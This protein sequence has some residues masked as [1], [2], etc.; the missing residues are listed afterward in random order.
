MNQL[1]EMVRQEEVKRR[2]FVEG[3]RRYTQRV[4]TANI[5]EIPLQQPI[6]DTII[7][8]PTQKEQEKEIEAKAEFSPEVKMIFKQSDNGSLE[9]KS[10]QQEGDSSAPISRLDFDKLKCKLD[11]ILRINDR[12]EPYAPSASSSDL[13]KVFNSLNDYT[14]QIFNLTQGLTLVNTKINFLKVDLQ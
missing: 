3:A 1:L 5:F 14:T 2:R 11:V 7:S 6:N 4:E 12:H 8:S 13:K 10:L 9:P